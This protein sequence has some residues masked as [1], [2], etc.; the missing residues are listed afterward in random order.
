MP[1]KTP[2]ESLLEALGRLLVRLLD[3][4]EILVQRTSE[5]FLTTSAKRLGSVIIL[6]P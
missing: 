3:F 4:S 1:R 5:R 6:Q 2:D